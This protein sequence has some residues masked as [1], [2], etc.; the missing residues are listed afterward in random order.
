MVSYIVN[1]YKYLALLLSSSLSHCVIFFVTCLQRSSRPTS[2]YKCIGDIAIACEGG[3]SGVG[4]EST[5]PTPMHRTR[6]T[7]RGGNQRR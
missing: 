2:V 6:S 5:P 1:K 7:D 3:L 4:D